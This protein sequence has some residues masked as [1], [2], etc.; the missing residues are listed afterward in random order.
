MIPALQ[1]LPGSPWDVLPAG[2]YPA[3]LQQ[4]SEA[5]AYNARR[6]LLFGGLLAACQSLVLAGC[7]TLFLDGSFVTAKPLPGDYDACW[8]PAGVDLSKLDKV[9]TDF[10]NKRAS[11][12]A[13]F[14]GEFFPSSVIA[15][16]IGRP[17]VEFFQND[18]FTGKRKGILSLSIATDDAVARRLI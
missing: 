14:L 6:R 16:D 5:F 11:Q 15:A 9:F 8:D 17:F 18:R 1:T 10:S 4:V 12:K 7:T 2:V 13:K 3:T